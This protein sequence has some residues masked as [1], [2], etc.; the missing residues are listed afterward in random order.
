[1][2]EDGKMTDNNADFLKKVS[3]LKQKDNSV[4]K[5]LH[6]TQD[7][8]GYIPENVAKEIAKIYSLPLSKLYS[9][10]TFYN[11]FK[12][13]KRGKHVFKVCLGTACKV[14]HNEKNLDFLK[15]EIGISIG[16]T[17]KD[18][19][20]TLESVN[21]FGACSLAPVVEIDGKI[22]AKMSPEKLKEHIDAIKGND[23]I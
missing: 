13:K 11:E 6:L 1:L 10:A 20:F 5:A 16:E 22:Y 21:C 23:K 17:S 7:V 4:I 19:L 14:N 15:K 9:V 3:D 2:I 12:L 18:N 8:F